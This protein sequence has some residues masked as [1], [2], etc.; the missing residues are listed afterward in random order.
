VPASRTLLPPFLLVALTVPLL[1]AGCGSSS[2]K[3]TTTVSAP[4]LT[5]KQFVS[6]ANAICIK[7]DRRVF[8]LGRLSLLPEGW[9]KTAAAARQGV[10]EMSV[11]HPPAARQAGFARMLRLG[12]Q[13][14]VGIQRVHDA[15]AK[16]NYK[17]AQAAQL[18]ATTADTA[19]H[20]QAK[21]LGLTFCQQ[22][23]T[24]WPA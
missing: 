5:Q 17:A 24:N 10:R 22:L 1:A 7:S 14:A 11:L 16:K 21:K 2:L 15:L 4:P 23:L 19:I 20:R 18:R 13:L 3:A 12:K 9:A 6:T 8:R